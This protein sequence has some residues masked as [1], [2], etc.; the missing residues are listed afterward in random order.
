MSNDLRRRLDRI[1][2][3]LPPCALPVPNI[4]AAPPLPSG[5]PLQD[6]LNFYKLTMLAGS[7]RDR[8]TPVVRVS[9]EDAYALFAEMMSLTST[10]EPTH[11]RRT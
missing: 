5:D 2:L 4:G 6:R 7:A 9:R 8:N 10:G 3:R 1:S 11:E